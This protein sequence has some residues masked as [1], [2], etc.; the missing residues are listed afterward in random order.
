MK[1]A[2]ITPIMNKESKIG[3]SRYSWVLYEGFRKN[4]L[5]VSVVKFSDDKIYEKLKKF[6][7]KIFPF[8]ALKDFLLAIFRKTE[9]YHFICPELMYYPLAIFQMYL[10]KKILRKK[11]VLTMHDMMTLEGSEGKSF[12]TI[13]ANFFIKELINYSDKIVANSI[14]TKKEIDAKIGL[15][16][17]KVEVVELGVEKE[18]IPQKEFENENFVVGYYGAFDEVEDPQYSLRCFNFLENKEKEKF[19][20]QMVGGGKEL[21][22]CVNLAKE[23]KIKNLTINGFSVEDESLLEYDSSS[24]FLFP[25]E[26]YN[27]F[28][29]LLFTSKYEGFGL[30]ILEAMACGVPVVIRDDARITPELKKLCVVGKNEEDIA[31]K[32]Y[33]VASDK[34]FRDKIIKKG[35]NAAKN[36]TWDKNVEKTI[37]IYRKLLKNE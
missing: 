16:K 19:S 24:L 8:W 17:K 28:D 4:N 25:V 35:L 7:N 1:V 13:I 20:M 15:N 14:Q 32:I 18:Y 31:N 29:I 5:E 33:E 23:L 34:E 30:N 36:F 12:S 22:N 6:V 3:M 27:S 26:T 37:K 21:Q 10:I 2:L 11:I 9:I